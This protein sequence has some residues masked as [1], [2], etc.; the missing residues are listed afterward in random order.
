MIVEIRDE[1]IKLGQAMKLAGC[2]DMGSDAK[3]LLEEGSVEVN[4]EV[5]TRRGRKL[6]DGDVFTVDGEDYL[7]KSHVS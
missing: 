5:E 4:G 6:Y 1:F 3:V 2:V 7:I